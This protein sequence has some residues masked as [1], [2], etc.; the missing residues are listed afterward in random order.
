[1]AVTA[2]KSWLVAFISIVVSAEI[3]EINK[4]PCITLGMHYIFQV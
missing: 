2:E 3:N 4:I 1:M